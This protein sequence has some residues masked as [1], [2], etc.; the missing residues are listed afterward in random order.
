[1]MLHFSSLP[2]F[3]IVYV[4]FISCPRVFM[5]LY[6]CT[7]FTRCFMSLCFLSYWIYFIFLLVDY[8]ITFITYYAVIFSLSR[9]TTILFL[10]NHFPSVPS[11]FIFLSSIRQLHLLHSLITSPLFLGCSYSSLN[12]SSPFMDYVSFGLCYLFSSITGLVF[13]SLLLSFLPFPRFIFSIPPILPLF[14]FQFYIPSLLL[15]YHLLSFPQ[16]LLFHPFI[17]K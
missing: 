16:F 13:L 2:V 17:T 9:V 5:S 3:M 11:V 6:M 1:M 10:L 12:I 4:C 15:F 7:D 8:S 14:M